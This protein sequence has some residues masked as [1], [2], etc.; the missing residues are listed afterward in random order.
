MAE[1]ISIELKREETRKEDLEQFA[2]QVQLLEFMN[3]VKRDQSQLQVEYQRQMEEI[4]AENTSLRNQ[5]YDM[6]GSGKKEGM[7]DG[8]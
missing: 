4:K 6:M 3:Q 5:L 2:A 1:K 7:D 8:K